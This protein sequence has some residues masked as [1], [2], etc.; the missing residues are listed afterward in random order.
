MVPQELVRLKGESVLL[1][2][3][4]HKQLKFIRIS[5]KSGNNNIVE[6]TNDTDSVLFYPKYKN[7]VQFD[8]KDYSL[9]I[10]HL[11]EGNN[12]IFKAVMIDI[13]GIDT[14][15]A[16]YSIVIQEKVR[17]PELLV[18]SISNISHSCNV[19]VTCSIGREVWATYSCN[20]FSCHAVLENYTK[21][22]G[23]QIDVSLD[24][25][26][27]VCNASNKVS[28]NTTSVAL[29]DSCTSEKKN[30]ISQIIII[31][32]T[33]VIILLIIVILMC[34]CATVKFKKFSKTNTDP[35][36]SSS[37]YETVKNN[38]QER[39]GN[40][41]SSG[42]QTVYDVMQGN[43]YIGKPQSPES[44]LRSI[45]STVQKFNKRDSHAVLIQSTESSNATE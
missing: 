7:R 18:N 28:W 38:G 35:E 1:T 41:P 19:S 14:T 27:I 30:F 33:L 24:G 40:L 29:K 4:G 39:P 20:Q 23:L 43:T 16:E 21:A 11:E 12:G 44:D 31:S 22:S 10:G 5:W 45:Y 6:Y 17:T 26:A 34:I 37:I 13:N 36:Q 3:P 2:V 25:G 15:V 8:K 9:R 32:I 42:I